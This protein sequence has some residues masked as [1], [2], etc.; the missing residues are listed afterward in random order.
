M[1]LKE[2]E[3]MKTFFAILDELQQQMAHAQIV[4]VCLL[5]NIQN[6]I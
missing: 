6:L 2:R 5:R 1:N 3:Y 4:H